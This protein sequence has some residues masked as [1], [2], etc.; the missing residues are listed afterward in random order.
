VLDRGFDF[1]LPNSQ[2]TK[3]IKIA[4]NTTMSQSIIFHLDENLKVY[5]FSKNVNPDDSFDQLSSSDQTSPK[6]LQK[7]KRGLVS[8]EESASEQNGHLQGSSGWRNS[9]QPNTFDDQQFRLELVARLDR[10][11]P[12]LDLAERF[13]PF[14]KELDSSQN[15][16]SPKLEEGSS[17]ESLEIFFWVGP[18]AGFTDTRMVYIW[19]KT[20]AMFFDSKLTTQNSPLSG[21]WP[22]K[23]PSSL[24]L[25]TLN[26]VHLEGLMTQSRQNLEQKL[27]YSAEPRIG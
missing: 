15:L 24:D 13:E 6:S 8:K 7:R 14:W 10:A 21:S 19:L 1:C 12:A 23:L 17:R 9:G 25:E 16:F 11:G 20:W 5:R 3:I 2:T 18:R 27:T 26:L 4:S 22:L